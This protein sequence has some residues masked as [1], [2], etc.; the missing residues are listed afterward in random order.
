MAVTSA[1][2]IDFLLANPGM[3][4]AQIVSAMDQYGVSPAQMAQAV[5]LP[6]TE[7]Q[8][9][10]EA[11]VAPPA[12]IPTATPAPA[13]V[14]NEQII[15]FL[16]TNPTLSDAAI[17]GVMQEYNVSPTQLAQAVGLPVNDIQQRYDAVVAPP[18]L[19][20]APV[21]A[22]TTP[23]P[24]VAPA[25]VTNQQIVEFLTTNPN[26]S[27]SQIAG[28]M[29]EYNV[30]PTQLAQA[31]GLPPEA[32]QERYVASA[33]NTYTA[34]NVNKLAA[35]ILAQG[36]TSAW[37]GGLPPETAAR[38]MADEL[39]KSG[40]T[41]INQV[42]K[43]DDGIINT[44]TGEKLI[45][46]YGERT[47][48]NL[49]SG[50]YEGKGNT[51]FGVNFDESGKPVF[52][53]QGAS[54]STLKN[55]VLKLAA[56]A[57]LAFGIPGVTEGLLSGTGA[58]GAGSS[59]GTGLTA[60]AGGLGLSTTGA[61]LGTLG[62]GAGITAGTGLGTGVLTGST[63][64]TGLLGAG[65]LTGVGVLGGSTLGT[66]LAGT[67]TGVTTGTGTA[68]GTGTAAG[69]GLG[70][71]AGTGLTT[72]G[73][74]LGTTLGTGLTAGAGGLG[75]STAGAGLGAAGTGAGITAGTGLGT[76]VLTGSGLG[77]S[78]LGTTG[79]GALTGTGVLAG[80]N[81]GTSLLGT[82]AGT[83]ATVGG[84]GNTV[85]NLGTG[86]LTTGL[87][88]LSS[89]LTGLGT[90]LTSG[91]TGLGNSLGTGL[92]GLGTG[93]GTGLTNTALANLLSTGL[94]TG[95]GLL[96]QQTSR[97]AAQRAQAMI[98]AETAAAK[99]AAA[100][101][102]VGMTTRFGTSQFQVDPVTGQ[103]TSAGYI[104]SP[105]AKNAQDRLVKL[106]ESGL[107]QA[108][109]AQ[110]QFAPLQTGAQNLFNLGNQ[111]LAQSPQ[112]VAQNY[113]NQQ[114]ALLQP[115]RELEL[116]NLQNRLQQQGRGGLSVAQ[117]GTMGAT[118]PEL[119]ALYN[120]RAQQE[121]Q[122]AANAQ[123]YGQQ[124]VSFGAGLLGQGSQAM[125]QYYGGQQ[126]AYAPY[127]TA[128]GQVQGLETAAQQPLTMGA[129]LGQQAATAG[130][131]VGRL[132]LS[133]AEFSTRLATGPAATTNPYS[134]LL[135][136]LGASPAFGQAF[137]GLFS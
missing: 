122:L 12:P 79:T 64:G 11:V 35:Q 17:V 63:L 99:Q 24:V 78:L 14:T 137:G 127:T 48:G 97:E 119:Q 39:A 71:V 37:T 27:D 121:A 98:D 13:P 77:T 25:T 60:G 84:L 68:L 131:N 62:T 134:T 86:A 33:P 61:G 110:A 66:T 94:T 106:A 118:T 101:R 4:D 55:D 5:G 112:D 38:Y 41:N 29:Q 3:S 16:T 58:L 103:L 21:V 133:G 126:A 111:Y 40:V 2:I 45:S 31:V 10:Y 75:L 34:E 123:Q 108:E 22:P 69:T 100:F 89:G 125:G 18:V 28:V 116:A 49:W 70:T 93:I 67:G 90:G 50:S 105:E 73:T 113:L 82:G 107:V 54:S 74:G 19:P 43:G 95:A 46:G 92:T 87:E 114:M 36:T 132:G 51:G 53:T 32:I 15:E 26:L 102:P 44:M 56:V 81:L 88:G 135:S 96:Q 109:G 30:T 65:A 59:L 124:Q 129:A 128:L 7:V 52:Y 42:A 9:R 20:T 120:A 76:G 130:A 47:G 23:A 83:A 1:Q 85:A 80:S 104:L 72:A 136:G 6:V 91:L 57:G 117:G 8:Q 115:G